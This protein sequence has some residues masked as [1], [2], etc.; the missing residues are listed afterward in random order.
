MALWVD[1]Y[2][3]NQLSKLDYHKEQAEQIQRIVR[4]FFVC[5]LSAFFRLFRLF[6]SVPPLTAFGYLDH[7]RCRVGE[8][9]IL[10]LPL[11]SL[12]SAKSVCQL[13][14]LMKI[15]QK[16]ATHHL[17]SVWVNLVQVASGDF[18]HLLVYGPPGAGKK[19]RIQCILRE[20]YG[21]GVERL[22]IDHKTFQTPSNKRIEIACV[23]SNYHIEINPG[24]VVQFTIISKFLLALVSTCSAIFSDVGIYDRIVVQEIV[25]SMAQ[26]QQ[27]FDSGS[28]RDFKSLSKEHRH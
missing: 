7:P 26:T 2:R 17:C 28:Q 3:P 10:H 12:D 4:L 1:K 9:R 8:G 5:K 15:S 18:P 21:V 13:P 24:F 25:K 14:D 6:Q 19:T 22:K 20:L 11:A 23:A 16:T 27:V